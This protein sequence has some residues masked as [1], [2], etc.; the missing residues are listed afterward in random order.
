MKKLLLPIFLLL[1]TW[2]SFAQSVESSLK[3][4]TATGTDTYAISEP[5]PSTYDPKERFLVRFTNAN[6]GPVTLNRFGL[7]A[8]AVQLAGA[9]PLVAG[10]IKAGETKLLS[11]NGTYYQIVGDGNSGGGGGGSGTVTSVS[12]T[13]INGVSGSVANPTTTPAISLTLGAITPSSV[14]ASGTV[15]GSNL[16][17][18]NTGDQDLSGLAVKSANLSDLTSAS[19]A[20]TNLGLGTLATQSGT[21]SGTSSGTNTGDQT[22][23]LTGNVTG[24]GTGSFA[25]TIASGAVTYERI[26]NVAA[27]SFLANLTGSGASLTEVATN[28]IPLFGSAI[29]GSPSSSTFLR[30]DGTWNAVD[31]SDK[32][33]LS[34]GGSLTANNTISGAFN[35]DFAPNRFQ[36]TQNAQ[37]SGWQSGLK[38]I[39]GAHT[40][41]NTAIIANDFQG[42]S[43]AFTG[44]AVPDQRFS[45]FRAFTA[46]GTAPTLLYNVFIEAPSGG[47]TNNALGLSGN[48]SITAANKMAIGHSAPLTELDIFTTKSGTGFNGASIRLRND[49]SNSDA[50]FFIANASATNPVWGMGIDGSDGGKFKISNDAANADVGV[51]TKF[52]IDGVTGNG[53][54]NIGLI[55]G[56]TSI[57]NASVLLDLQSVTQALV[58]PRMTTGNRDAI[59]TIIDGMYIYNST[60]GKHTFRQGGAWVELGGGSGLNFQQVLAI[61]VLKL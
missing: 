6:T 43:W 41:V 5:I 42:T 29:T 1:L 17:G 19:T 23:T 31:L 51:S 45:L 15:T 44:T 35:I 50:G 46:T 49:A 58:V 28:R 54:F 36:V 39:Q 26:Q 59:A 8:K 18:T 30:G 33:S 21:F 48:L 53:G 3:T 47:V 10:D 9:A 27:N 61:S 52:F 34:S 37:S 16:S 25:A 2:A 20:R 55:V 38:V 7:G 4:V 13:T 32:W 24:S 12:V 14:A 56:G 11:Y 57:T 60:T 22:I 40:A